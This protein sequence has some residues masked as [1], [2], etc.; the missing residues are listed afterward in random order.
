MVLL[1]IIL[2]LFVAYSLLIALYWRNWSRARE[3][4]AGE[5]NSPIKVSIIIPAR[6]EEENI[7]KLLESL[8]RQSY[9]ANFTE[10]I[11]IDDHSTDRTASIVSEFSFVKLISLKD[12]II[13]SYK[14]K[15]IEKGIE[16][17]SGEL[18][19]TTDAD[20]LPGKD[21]L[22]SIVS[23]KIE[24]NAVFV[25]APVVFNNNSSL[26][27]TLQAIDFL[28]LQGITAASVSAKTY[29]MCN[30][31]NMA[32]ERKAF[33][34]VNGFDGIDHIASGDD[35][36]LMHKIRDKYPEQ[37]YYLKSGDAIISTE[38]MKT[39]RAFINQRIRWASKA[40]HYQDAKIIAVLVLVYLFNLSFLAL[41]VL[42]FFN[43][44]YWIWL[45]GSWIAK[46]AIE[47][48]FVYAVAGFYKKR[49][50]L[51]YFFFL[52]PLHIAYTI[53][54]GFLGL[55]GKYEWKGRRVR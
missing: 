55:L 32:Y 34:E 40:R 45:G 48:P 2:L 1:F 30:G 12:D 6:N 50:L 26:L 43:Y 21:W 54:S 52:Q 16:T 53:I 51:K 9:P 37:I 46:T 19:I 44:W 27:Q 17:A 11:V 10:V 15:A 47:F 18:I 31:A 38:P 29:A 20:C 36:L 14:K 13:N 3:C 4:T 7:G 23:F 39:W 22:R 49:S 33:I 28:V 41:F 24:K 8:K 25:A 35:M 5:I 42:G